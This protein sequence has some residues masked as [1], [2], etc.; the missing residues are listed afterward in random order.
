MGGSRLV[1]LAIGL[2]S[3]PQA[4]L[5]LPLR[6]ERVDARAVADSERFLIGSRGAVD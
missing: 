6:T 5:H 3:K 1:S 4:E 2:E